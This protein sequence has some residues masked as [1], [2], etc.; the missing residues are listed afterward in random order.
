MKLNNKAT[1]FLAGAALAVITAVGS[2]SAMARP[3]YE[4][5]INYQGPNG[6]GVGFTIYFCNGGSFTNGQVTETFNVIRTP[7]SDFGW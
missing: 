1:K 7:C 6:G 3:S 4:V 2:Y 5:E